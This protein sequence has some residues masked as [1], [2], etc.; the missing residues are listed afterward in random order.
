M[1]RAPLVVRL[2]GR[3]NET[4]ATDN[5]RPLGVGIQKRTPEWMVSFSNVSE[6]LLGGTILM[7]LGVGKRELGMWA[8]RVKAFSSVHSLTSF[9][10]LF[11]W[12]AELQRYVDGDVSG[13][14]L[15]SGSVKQ[16]PLV[17][18]IPAASFAANA[19]EV[20]IRGIVIHGI[21]LLRL[22]WI[23]GEL[24]IMQTLVFNH[25]RVIRFQQQLDRLI[26]HCNVLKKTTM[27][28][29]FDQKGQVIGFSIACND[30][31]RNWHGGVET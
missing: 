26:L 28:T 3:R 10:E 13:T 19:E 22:G 30:V 14:L 18:M 9:T 17:L 2:P 15:T 6:A 23:R 7:K 16:S 25:C 11:G 5:V 27:V 4:L 12:N 8:D 24:K 1:S 29:S 20:M 31:N 21:T